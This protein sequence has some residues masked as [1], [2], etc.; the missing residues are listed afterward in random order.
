MA[1]PATADGLARQGRLL[2][3]AG[4]IEEAKAAYLEALR[5]DPAHFAALNDFGA[6]LYDTDY[7]AAARTVFTQAVTHHPD[8]PLG[9]VN[10]ANLLMYANEPEAAR[11]HYETAL[12]LDPDN[13][14]AHQRLSALFHDLGDAEA[15]ER[16]RRLGF[17]AEPMRT[18]PYLG[19]GEPV[20]LLA[21]TSTPGGDIAWRRLVDDRVFETTALA[22]AHH[23]PAAALPPHRLIFN[24]IGDADVSRADLEAAQRLIARSDAP[25]V[26]PA[27]QGARHLQGPGTPKGSPHCQ[28]W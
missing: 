20:R 13:A 27:G 10:L 14:Q 18:W 5:L 11:A 26:E 22:A 24:A 6:L 2:A 25:V 9:H 7:R 19:D 12:R 1:E 21:L 17:G 3:Q 16:H 4:R 8:E 15:M 28:A 23:D